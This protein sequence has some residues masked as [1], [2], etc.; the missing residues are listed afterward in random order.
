MASYQEFVDGQ[1]DST[2][3]FDY[4]GPVTKTLIIASSPRSG[5]H[6]LGHV[7]HQ[8]RL[9]GH[10]LEYMQPAHHRRWKQH[11]GVSTTRE[12]F[13]SLKHDRTSPNGVFSAK[14]HFPHLL[15][16]GGMSAIRELFPDP[17][18]VLL[19]RR[20]TVKQAVSLTLARQSGL[21]FGESP[22]DDQV[23]Y[24]ARAIDKALSDA[25]RQTADWRFELL[26]SGLPLLEIDFEDVP[27]DVPGV[28]R[29]IADFM[30]VDIPDAALPQEPSTR[31][32]SSTLNATW[33]EQY[34][35]QAQSMRTTGIS[36][37]SVGASGNRLQSALRTVHSLR[38]KLGK[39]GR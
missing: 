13:A 11:Y 21:W 35:S 12:V 10:P 28:T 15:D 7:L 4:D 6:M 1:Y 9:L 34:M 31:Q 30:G 19:R 39:R 3:N 25:I 17:H 26:R 22:S 18:F 14:L 2:H 27:K 24:D 16:I 29:R 5:S 37:A 20:D 33:R 38:E 36:G 32:Q 8:T 23:E